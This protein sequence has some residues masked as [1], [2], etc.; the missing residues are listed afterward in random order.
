[1]E[2]HIFVV[3]E[4]DEGSLDGINSIYNCNLKKKLRKICDFFKHFSVQYGVVYVNANINC[5]CN[6]T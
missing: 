2:S 4:Y 5:H 6:I 1:M 3:K